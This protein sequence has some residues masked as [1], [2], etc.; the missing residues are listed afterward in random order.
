MW[1]L[2]CPAVSL[3]TEQCNIKTR[4]FLKSEQQMLSYHILNFT[5]V[6][7][8][9]TT[10]SVKSIPGIWKWNIAKVK[11]IASNRICGQ[12]LLSA[13]TIVLSTI[14]TQQR[15]SKSSI[16]VPGSHPIVIDSV[17]TVTNL[18][19]AA[20]TVTN[21]RLVADFGPLLLLHTVEWGLSSPH[22]CCQAPE[23]WM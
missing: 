19:L 22:H 15:L 12:T 6:L 10:T 16:L 17:A 11:I 23:L 18:R 13:N 21:L 9:E 3:E 20:A 7:L 4:T 14:Q 1:N 5:L 8:T 2:S